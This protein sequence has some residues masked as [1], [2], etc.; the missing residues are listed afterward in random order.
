MRQYLNVLEKIK[1]EGIDREG[2]NAVTRALFT[3]PMRF[4]MNDGFP[5]VTTKKLAFKSAAA[6]LLWFLEGGTTTKRLKEIA[7]FDLKIWDGDARQHFEKGKA[8]KLGDLGPV[9]GAQWR[10]WPTG[11]GRLVDQIGEIIDRIK[12]NPFDRRLIVTAWNPADIDK[13]ALPPCHMIFQFFVTDDKRL[14]LHMFQRSC[15]MFLGVPFNIASYALLLHMVAHVTDLKP[16]ECILTLGD[17][18]IYHQH[19]D[20]VAEQLAR[21]PLPPPALWLNPEVKHIDDFTME[22]IQLQNYQHHPA[23]KAP[24]LTEDIN[25][26]TL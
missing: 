23:I 11:D 2:R 16:W 5:A 9:Y 12:T 20:Q 19:W 17:A 24:L 7:G 4:D 14:S 15:D 21:S 8:A 6:E 18:H 10:A 13:M 3:I 25:R 26:K 1:N 22:D